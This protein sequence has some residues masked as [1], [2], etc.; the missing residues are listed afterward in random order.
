MLPLEVI[1]LALRGA[2]T[3]GEREWH[4]QA[5]GCTD[6]HVLHVIRLTK[7]IFWASQEHD[8]FPQR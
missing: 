4:C 8:V 6:H 7:M 5:I 3:G 1:A 2:S